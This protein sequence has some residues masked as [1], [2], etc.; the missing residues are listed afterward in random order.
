M[1][2]EG[3]QGIVV[4]P[5]TVDHRRGHREFARVRDDAKRRIWVLPPSESLIRYTQSVEAAI[6]VGG[7]TPKGFPFTNPD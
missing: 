5:Q 1:Y 7:S 3:N 6:R 4:V 2:P